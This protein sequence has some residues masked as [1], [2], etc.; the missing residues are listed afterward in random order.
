M[1]IDLDGDLLLI[2][3]ELRH[4]QSVELRDF[5][6]FYNSTVDR[7]RQAVRY[8][9]GRGYL[10]GGDAEDIVQQ[11]YEALLVRWERVGRIGA[12]EQYLRTVAL[13]LAK[14]ALGR[15]NTELL[16][17][18]IA[19]VIDTQWHAP[20]PDTKAD[21][22]WV[23]TMIR[24]LPPR[25]AQITALAMY[26]YTDQDTADFLGIT[27]GSVRSHRRHTRNLL[28]KIYRNR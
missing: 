1:P 19:D 15:R 2:D 7:I 3:G 25:Q 22:D 18:E 17:A 24:Q 21:T 9:I 4:R 16:T 12:P 20:A 27:V 6:E 13:N 10:E 11:A 8:R 14:R 5:T 23:W 28:A 26:G